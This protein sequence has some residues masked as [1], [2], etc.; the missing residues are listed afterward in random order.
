MGD[1][2]EEADEENIEEVSVTMEQWAPTKKHKKGAVDEDLSET[3]SLEDDKYW[4]DD[5]NLSEDENE[6]DENSVQIDNFDSAMIGAAAV[7][8]QDTE[9][10]KPK[11]KKSKRKSTSRRSSKIDKS[12]D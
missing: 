11:K 9:E 6:P 5:I 4:D 7:P 8:D 1:K 10:E 2:R 12:Y 3:E